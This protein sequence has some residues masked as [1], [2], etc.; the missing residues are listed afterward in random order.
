VNLP[1]DHYICYTSSFPYHTS[2]A[3]QYTS[4]ILKANNILQKKGS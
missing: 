4:H 1:M 3:A 2:I